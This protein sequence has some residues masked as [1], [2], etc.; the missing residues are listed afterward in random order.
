MKKINISSIFSLFYIV[1]SASAGVG[2][3]VGVS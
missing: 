3:N 1:S 2:I